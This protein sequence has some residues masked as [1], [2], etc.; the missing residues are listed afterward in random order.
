M[1]K[2]PPHLETI[3]R[4]VSYERTFMVSQQD[5]WFLM[6]MAS[7]KTEYFSLFAG[8]MMMMMMM[9][10]HD[11]KDSKSMMLQV[12]SSLSWKVLANQLAAN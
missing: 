11:F 7:L 10:V 4:D 9:E 5:V 12:K 6:V 8:M 2:V 1:T 3:I